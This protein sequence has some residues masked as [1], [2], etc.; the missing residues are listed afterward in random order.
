MELWP[1]SKILVEAALCHDLGEYFTGDSPWPVKQSNAVFKKELS[2][3]ETEHLKKINAFVNLTDEEQSYLKIA[4][5][6]EVM[7]YA[8]EEI[9]MGNQLFKEI[10]ERAKT[11][12][13]MN[14]VLQDPVYR[15]INELENRYKELTNAS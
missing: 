3:M 5:M 7:Y 2:T 12:L 1:Q 10:F 13:I 4:D 8:L 6:L 14:T 9:T 11:Y 15:I